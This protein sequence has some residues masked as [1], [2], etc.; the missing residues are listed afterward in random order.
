MEHP[1]ISDLSEKTL[2]ELQTVIN[3]LMPKLTFA[4]RTQNRALIHQLTM[5]LDSY[6]NE[7]NKKM[8]KI[9][10]KQQLQINIEKN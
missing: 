2:D 1:F 5:A 4:Y 7:H 8:D 10:Q 9:I 3:S 6:R